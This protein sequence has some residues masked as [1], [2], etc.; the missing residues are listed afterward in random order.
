[1]AIRRKHRV[2]EEIKEAKVRLANAVELTAQYG[3]LG[4]GIVST[5]EAIRMAAELDMDLVEIAGR[6]EPPVCRIMSYA[7][8]KEDLEKREQAN[9][10]R[11]HKAEV[12][13]IRFGS[14]TDEQDFQFKLRHAENFLQ[15]GNRLKAYVLLRGKQVANKDQVKSVLNR[16]AEELKPYGEMEMAPVMEGHR[17]AMIIAPKK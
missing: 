15:D 13:E 17:M 14:K 3:D 6:A 16:F 7:K 10:A 11:Q 12:K 9:K 2:N 1:M 5:S 8:F 4:E